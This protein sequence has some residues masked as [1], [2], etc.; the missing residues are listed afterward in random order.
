M[1]IN[2]VHRFLLV[3]L[4]IKTILGE[5]TISR[6]RQKLKAMKN[7]LDL[8]GAYEA[9][10]G[11]IMAQG[12]EKARLGMAAMMW[13]SHSRRPLQADEICHAIAIRIG[14]ND[15]DNDDIPT[16]PTLLDSCQGLVTVNKGAPTVRL[17]H[18]TLQEHLRAHPYLFGRAHSTMAETCLT[19]LNLRRIKDLPASQL[20]NPRDTPFLEY[21]SLYWGTHMQTELSDRAITFALQL[22][23]RF[24]SHV[25]AKSL[26]KSIH[27]ESRFDYDPD[28]TPFSALHCISYFG[29]PEVTKALINTNRWDV[30]QRDSAGM[31]PLIWAARYG[32]RQVVSLLLR[33]Q[34]IQPDQQD[35]NYGRTALSWAAGN[36]HEGVVR[37]FLGP[38]FVNPGSVGCWWGK[39]AQAVDLLLGGRYVDPDSSSK[40]CRTPLSWA[41]EN[42]NEGIVKLLLGRKDVNPNTPDTEY[43]QTPLFWAAMN[44]HE[45][46]VRLLLERGDL[47]PDTPDTVQGLTPL[48]RASNNGHE[49]IVKLLLERKDVN[50]NALDTMRGRTPLL[51]AVRNGHERIVKLLL[52]RKDVNP[53]TPDIE[54]GRTPLSWAA[55]NG[56]EGIVK[57]LL[58]QKDVNPDTPDTAFG[59]TPLSL[60]AQQGHEGIV[61]LLLGRKDVNPNTPDTVNGATPLLRASLYG[62]EGVVKLLLE[63][64]AVNPDTPDTM[65]GRT[66]L[67]W[68]AGKGHGGIVRLLLVREDVNPNSFSKFGQTPLTLAAENGHIKVVDLLLLSS[69][70]VE[71]ASCGYR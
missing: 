5:G 26:W 48:S 44:G 46:I 24:N 32:N 8:G 4:S 20:P 38:Q 41:A 6:R 69:C 35:A 16:L 43:G 50:P 14:S 13:I 21:S 28:D 71:I 2:S 9:M 57:L 11:R 1:L 25:S 3:F 7:G 29:I 56:H 64:T 12:G 15:L 42:G 10:L 31:T 37:L 49:R 59:A 65:Y 52:G 30:N 40:Y 66:P 34:D 22:L 62:H 23:G 60:A 17:V 58:Q 68:A 61:K 33:K 18:F 39:A 53:D 63:Q 36:G 55:G 45:G 19:Y 67:S 51:W 47:N 70:L 54:Y 27:A